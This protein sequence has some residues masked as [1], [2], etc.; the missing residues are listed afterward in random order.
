MNVIGLRSF[1]KTWKWLVRARLEASREMVWEALCISARCSNS[2][3]GCYQRFF[4]PTGQ[5]AKTRG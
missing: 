2:R 4:C 5:P 3:T 1:G